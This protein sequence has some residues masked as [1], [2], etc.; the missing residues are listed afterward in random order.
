MMPK[1][2]PRDNSL[3]TRHPESFRDAGRVSRRRGPLPPAAPQHR[4][5]ALLLQLV[6]E[7]TPDLLL[8]HLQRWMGPMPPADE[9]LPDP[10]VGFI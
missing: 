1:N 2:P 5:M 10:A 4:G 3:D 7:P 8:A 9:V 6:S